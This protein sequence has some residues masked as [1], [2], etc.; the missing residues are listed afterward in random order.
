MANP[1]LGRDGNNVPVQA[2]YPAAP[3]NVTI[4]GVSQLLV[5]PTATQFLRVASTGN[6]YLEFGTSGAVATT[7][8]ALFPAGSEM[9]KIPSG[10]THVAAIQVGAATGILSI[11]R[12]E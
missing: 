8:S 10:V 2:L 5:I 12:M 11:N 7:A 3:V 9:F 6:V 4:S 1:S